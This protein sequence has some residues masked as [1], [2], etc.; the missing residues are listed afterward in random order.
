MSEKM[1]TI[2]PAQY[3]F[4]RFFIRLRQPRHLITVAP[5]GNGLVILCSGQK[6]EPCAAATAYIHAPTAQAA[7]DL[8][9][10]ECL[11]KWREM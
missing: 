3:E 5:S 8:I 10:P 2:A 6:N 9:C 4:G 1:P 11:K 7:C